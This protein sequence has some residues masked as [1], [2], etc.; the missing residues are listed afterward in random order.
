VKANSS[1]GFIA[2]SEAD[3]CLADGLCRLQRKPFA[4]E[5][6]LD[7]IAIRRNIIEN[8]YFKEELIL[9]LKKHEI[10]YTNDTS[11]N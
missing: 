3:F 5:T 7:Y 10:E 11:S 8:V 1:A 6:V 4:E 9:F 2:S